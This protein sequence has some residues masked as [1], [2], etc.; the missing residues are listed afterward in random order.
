MPR[1]RV[2]LISK[3][4]YWQVFEDIPDDELPPFALKYVAN[5]SEIQQQRRDADAIESKPTPSK[6]SARRYVKRDDTF[7]RS[8][9]VET[10]PGEPLYK[11]DLN[12]TPPRYVRYG[13]VR[14][15]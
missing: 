1:L 4:K 15:D 3:G 13:K 11:R 9:S 8:D 10:I 12:A 7:K 6:L 5:E 2:S 14:S